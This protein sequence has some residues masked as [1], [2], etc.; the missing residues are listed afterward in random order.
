MNR[1]SSVDPGRFGS[2][3][4]E[5]TSSLSE[6][7]GKR[8]AFWVK[9]IPACCEEL[10]CVALS[11]EQAK[12]LYKRPDGTWPLGMG[13]AMA[14][15]ARLRECVPLEQYRGQGRRS[16]MVGSLVGLVMSPFRWALGGGDGGDSAVE[17]DE[18]QVFVFEA[19]LERVGRRVLSELE[20][21]GA[22]FSEAELEEC[23]QRRTGS[24]AL[25]TTLVL[26]WL[27]ERRGAVVS[28]SSPVGGARQA[29]CTLSDAV[30]SDLDVTVYQLRSV[31]AALRK[32]EEELEQRSRSL[33]E[34]AAAS[35]R[36]GGRARAAVL[37]KRKRIVD[38]ALGKRMDIG[39][40]VA[41]VL[42]RVEAAQA[43]RMVME[44]L[45]RGSNALRAAQLEPEDVSRL[46]D[47]FGELAA[48]Q[49][50]VS[51]VFA[52]S[53]NSDMVELE[54]E[55]AELSMAPVAQEAPVTAPQPAV[56]AVAAVEAAVQQQPPQKE[57][58][59]SVKKKLELV[60]E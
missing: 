54:K 57:Q 27:R 51:D 18:T 44:A 1:G 49:D 33:R 22:I 21:H 37:L 26:E 8:L 60:T 24:R 9:E 48:V 4:L 56:A 14:E 6:V 10:G 13:R 58:Q 47:E 23:V 25:D 15:L 29:L 52:A 50:E 39:T 55:L 36:A 34:E 53:A 12:Q 7:H 41:L 35:V 46:L 40:N 38:D 43:D 28:V 5:P 45:Q 59:H 11:V 32:Q 2:I 42:A 3:P 17:A 19:V 20:R 16:S 31:A 30:V